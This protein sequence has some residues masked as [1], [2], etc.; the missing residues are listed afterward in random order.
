MEEDKKELEHALEDMAF[1]GSSKVYI[2][3]KTGKYLMETSDVEITVDGEALAVTAEQYMVD[4]GIVIKG[5]VTADGETLEF[6]GKLTAKDGKWAYEFDLSANGEKIASMKFGLD[7][8]KESG[9]YKLYVELIDN[10][11]D[12][13]IEM[14]VSGKYNESSDGFVL[15]VEN[16]YTN[17]GYEETNLDLVIEIKANKKA[18]VNKPEGYVEILEM[19][20]DELYEVIGRISG[21]AYGLSELLYGDDYYYEDDY[22]DEDYEEF[23]ITYDD[24]EDYADYYTYEE[25]CELVDLYNSQY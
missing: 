22:Y 20:E 6:N 8:N 14:S 4:D 15:T 25:F 3:K 17:D 2:D 11:S 16:I 7:Y 19:T 1:S 12:E 23:T 13:T 18:D 9:N 24:Y 10:E 21:A 5:E